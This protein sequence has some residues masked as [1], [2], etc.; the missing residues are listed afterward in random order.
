MV[1]VGGTVP[2]SLQ[3]FDGREDLTVMCAVLD[4]DLKQIA[5]VQLNHVKGGLY[6]S[7]QVLMPDVSYLIA[8]YIVYEG[9]NESQDYER[10]SDVF[11]AVPPAQDIA[12]QVNQMFD[13]YIPKKDDYLTGQIID[14]SVDQSI[15]EGKIKLGT[16]QAEN[17]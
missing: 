5:E 3:L 11:Y 16:N 9:E 14:E 6:I 4:P 1:E 2:L 7:R 12:G 13:E 8:H 10:A 15:L 17:N